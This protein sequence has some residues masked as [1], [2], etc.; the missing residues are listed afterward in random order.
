MATAAPPR[1]GHDGALVFRTDPE[2]Q[3]LRALKLSH[4]L[5]AHPELGGA[6]PHSLRD[7]PRF[8]KIFAISR[9]RKKRR[10]KKF[11]S[12]HEAILR[13]WMEQT[14]RRSNQE[15]GRTA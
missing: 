11:A 15:K 8:E 12:T 1:A 13:I 6:H 14:G 3:V 7:V 9:Q 5:E 2:A 4:S 10:N